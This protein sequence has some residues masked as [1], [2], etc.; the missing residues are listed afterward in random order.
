MHTAEVAPVID[1]Q[2]VAVLSDMIAAFVDNA[3]PNLA[4]AKLRIPDIEIDR[5]LSDKYGLALRDEL[6]TRF[7]E[8]LYYISVTDYTG[9][10]GR[11]FADVSIDM[12]RGLAI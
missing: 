11:K 12:K 5:R 8:R 6:C 4:S 9:R 10:N 1:E 3:D 2:I 7:R